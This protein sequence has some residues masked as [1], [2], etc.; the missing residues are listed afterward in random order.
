MTMAGLVQQEHLFSYDS[1]LDSEDEVRFGSNDGYDSSDAAYTS[2][3]TI[4][5]DENKMAETSL[6][7]FQDNYGSAG[8]LEVRQHKLNGLDDR[9]KF[10]FSIW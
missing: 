4:T 9:F 5:E 3:G 10:T 7:T 2:D 6:D 1:P 8:K